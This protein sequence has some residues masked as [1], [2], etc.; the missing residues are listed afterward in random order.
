METI[1]DEG[2]FVEFMPQLWL[3]SN[4]NCALKQ[5]DLAQ[6]YFPRRSQQQSKDTYLRLLKQA[7]FMCLKPQDDGKWELRKGR[8]LKMNLGLLLHFFVISSFV[9]TKCVFYAGSLEEALSAEKYYS[10]YFS[11]TEAELR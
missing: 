5:R 7:K 9:F 3:V 10:D 4:K 2:T 11:T 1:F 8:I 6:F